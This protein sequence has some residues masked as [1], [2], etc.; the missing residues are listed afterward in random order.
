MANFILSPFFVYCD[1]GGRTYWSCKLR[2]QYD[3]AKILH[4]FHCLPITNQSIKKQKKEATVV[5]DA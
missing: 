5:M 1:G 3:L 2:L 4:H